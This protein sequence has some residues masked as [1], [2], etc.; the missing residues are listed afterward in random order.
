MTQS[1]ETG[2]K[3]CVTPYRLGS[4]DRLLDP[5]CQSPPGMSGQLPSPGPGRLLKLV[6][7]TLSHGAAVGRA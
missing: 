5:P 3:N 6:M 7:L 2:D 4:P 1:D